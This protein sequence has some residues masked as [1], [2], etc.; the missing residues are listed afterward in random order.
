MPAGERR[1]ARVRLAM[2]CGISGRRTTADAV[3]DVL[4]RECHRATVH[5][6]PFVCYVSNNF[7]SRVAF[8]PSSCAVRPSSAEMVREDSD[9]V[10]R[11]ALVSLERCASSAVLAAT[12]LAEEIVSN[13]D[14]ESLL[15]RSWS[16][17]NAL[18]VRFADTGATRAGISS[19][20]PLPPLKAWTA[21]LGSIS[22]VSESRPFT[23]AVATEFD[24]ELPQS[25]AGISSG[26]Q[27]SRLLR[28]APFSLHATLSAPSLAAENTRLICA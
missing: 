12:M 23:T 10:A 24:V 2:S 28:R 7:E 13:P 17:P 9:S 25:S 20:S 18:N 27:P 22:W 14:S 8:A 4:Q 16:K 15:S 11:N 21:T 1:S 5:Q 26:F 3:C 19:T 6:E